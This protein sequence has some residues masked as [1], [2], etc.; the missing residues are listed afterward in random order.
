MLLPKRHQI[1][2]LEFV[3]SWFG[4]RGSEVQ[5]LSLPDQIF[6]NQSIAVFVRYASDVLFD[7]SRSYFTGFTGQ[8]L[9]TIN[10]IGIEM[11]P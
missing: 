7:G 8:Q 2:H 11:T 5:I 4:T 6:C 9:F 3:I 10:E 1:K